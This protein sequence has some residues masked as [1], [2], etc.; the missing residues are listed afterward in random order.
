MGFFGL[1][2][3]P[4]DSKA[5]NSGVRYV[6][7]R[8]GSRVDGEAIEKLREY[9]LGPAVNVPNRKLLFAAV[10]EAMTNVVHHAYPHK[11]HEQIREWWLAAAYDA[12]LRVLVILI[13]DQGDGIPSTLPRKGV[14]YFQDML[15]KSDGLRI[16]AAHELSRS[17]SGESYRGHGLKRDIQEYVK[18][19]KGRGTYRVISG[20]GE[21]VLET[22]TDRSIPEIRS[23]KRR[24]RGTLIEWRLEI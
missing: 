23:K 7:F 3:I 19:F 8:S 20:R 24:L 14:E 10:T 18:A 15:P 6:Q 13:Y 1:L 21:Y 5:N 17:T 4:R 2:G 12:E 22:G 9:D 11:H 16:K